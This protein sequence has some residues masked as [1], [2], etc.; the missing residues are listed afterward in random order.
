[1]KKIL[2]LLVLGFLFVGLSCTTRFHFGVRDKCVSACVPLEF[3]ET[4]AAIAR[5]ERSPGAKSCPGKIT[6]AKELARQGAE[7][8]WAGRTEEGMRLLAEARQMAQAGEQCQHLPP[9]P[10][11]AAKP[12]P[13]PSP[14]PAP[15]PKPEPS[16]PSP[17]PAVKAEPLPPPP[18]PP[19]KEI[20][21]KWVYFAFN[22]STLT[23]Q[24]KAT[25]DE[26]ARILKEKPR[27]QAGTGRVYRRY[28]HGS[29][30]QGALRQAKQ[31]SLGLSGLER[32][33][34]LPHAGRR[35]RRVQSRGLQQNR[36]GP[37]QEPPGRVENPEVM[38]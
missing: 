34:G 35:L 13:P 28:G 37:G 11:P 32:D 17:P 30:Q 36:G 8:Y 2:V 12:V 21:L 20:S 9:V 31:G 26:T 23:R 19:K 24:A 29:L 6:G 7:A 38:G 25:L 14:A 16:P 10:A 3:D 27:S 18:P 15:V 1:M 4:E 33:R 22:K 5:A